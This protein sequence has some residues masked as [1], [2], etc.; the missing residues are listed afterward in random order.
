M[1][2][3]LKIMRL[4]GLGK[5]SKQIDPAV[6]ESGNAGALPVSDSPEDVRETMIEISEGLSDCISLPEKNND[7][8]AE[9]CVSICEALKFL[10]LQQ[11]ADKRVW[12]YLTHFVFWDYARARWPMPSQKSDEA[13]SEWHERKIRHVETHYFV[14]GARGLSV[15]GA[16]GLIRGN[17]IS[18]LF[19]M[20]RI[21][22]RCHPHFSQTQALQI[23]LKRADVRANL[24][25]RPTLSMSVEIFNAVMITL[26][27]DDRNE[28]EEGLFERETF[29]EFMKQLN[30]IGGSRMLNV[31]PE[32]LLQN[33]VEKIGTQAKSSRN[34]VK[35]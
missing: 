22:E 24:L 9:N 17:A 6:Y 23:L 34:T 26:G 30:R 8:D 28:K 27:K 29:R 25:E 15:G 35:T 4:G 21:A 7:R 13:D 11:A 32:R 3:R 18:R 14:D 2:A 12:A 19:W 10:T 20:G 1:S 31:L 16:R 33:L 5:L